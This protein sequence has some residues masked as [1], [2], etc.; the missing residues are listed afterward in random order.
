[1]KG[2]HPPWMDALQLPYKLALPLHTY[3][4]RREHFHVVT[5]SF[6]YETMDDLKPLAQLKS[7]NFAKPL[8]LFLT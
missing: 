6:V 3:L 8:T 7:Y 2:T 5:R 4:S 1:M